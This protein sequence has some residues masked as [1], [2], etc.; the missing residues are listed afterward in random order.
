[1]DVGAIHIHILQNKEHP[2]RDN[3]IP[4]GGG[5]AISKRAVTSD[6]N[7]G[8]RGVPVPSAA[9]LSTSILSFDARRHSLS[10]LLSTDFFTP[11]SII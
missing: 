2:T 4:P 3:I 11:Y 8:T 9:F 10:S 6:G 5:F 1:M 7:G